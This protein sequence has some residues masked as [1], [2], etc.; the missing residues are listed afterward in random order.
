MIPK[1]PQEVDEIRKIVLHSNLICYQ[2]LLVV[3]SGGRRLVVPNTFD[4]SYMYVGAE[5]DYFHKISTCVL[6]NMNVTYGGDRYKT[7]EPEMR[8]NST[9]RNN[10][11]T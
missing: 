4:I 5:N 10:Y 11:H 2:S 7:F 8:R 3:I 9:C 1:N 6:E